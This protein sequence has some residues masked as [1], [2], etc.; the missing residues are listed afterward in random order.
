MKLKD[1][2]QIFLEIRIPIFTHFV[3]PKYRHEFQASVSFLGLAP[4]FHLTYFLKLTK[5]WPFF[6][7]RTETRAEIQNLAVSLHKNTTSPNS[8]SQP[9]IQIVVIHRQD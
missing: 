5:P 4:C 9:S 7:K 3:T 2:F 1:C 6:I 8:N